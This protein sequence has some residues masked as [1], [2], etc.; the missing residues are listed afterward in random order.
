MLY[1]FC[2]NT[3]F[4]GKIL[5]IKKFSVFLK[6]LGL[7]MKKY[8][9]EI[10]LGILSILLFIAIIVFIKLTK[11]QF[12]MDFTE[13]V[14]GARN[15]FFNG[16]F[17]FVTFF[18]GK[19]FTIV[20]TVVSYVFLLNMHKEKYKRYFKKEKAN[21][22]FNMLKDWFVMIGSV[23]LVTVLFL[24]LKS[25]FVRTR[26]IEWFLVHESGWSFPS[27]HTATSFAMYGTFAMLVSK[28]LKKRWQRYTLSISAVALSWLI[29]FSRIYL[30]VHYLTDVLAGA[31]L[32]VFVVCV[33]SIVWKVMNKKEVKSLKEKKIK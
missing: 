14:A 17:K 26:P 16:F 9:K 13:S 7:K 10:I 30:G 18:G 8:R 19:I 22:F 6:N 2:A 21:I 15:G 5:K 31:A 24:T 11:E 23:V 25:I 29:G 20:F 12:D 32:G 3:V 27:G 1:F 28:R 4:N 33:A